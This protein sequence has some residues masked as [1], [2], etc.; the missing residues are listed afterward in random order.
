MSL[1]LH[2]ELIRTMLFD[3]N[4][5]VDARARAGEYASLLSQRWVFAE[6]AGGKFLMIKRRQFITLL[7]GAAVTWPLS[8]EVIE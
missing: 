4:S 1:Q 3:R 5:D 6:Q 2:W 8:D 7:G